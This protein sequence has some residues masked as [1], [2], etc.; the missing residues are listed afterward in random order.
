MLLLAPAH[1]AHAASMGPCRNAG[2]SRPAPSPSCDRSAFAQLPTES[3]Q[4]QTQ[5]QLPVHPGCDR[6]CL[7]EWHY[8]PPTRG[9][10]RNQRG[11]LSP[12]PFADHVPQSPDPAVY[13]WKRALGAM[14]PTTAPVW[15]P[16]P[17]HLHSSHRW[18][19]ATS[20]SQFYKFPELS[21]ICLGCP[22]K[23]W[24]L[25][26]PLCHSAAA[27]LAYHTPA[28]LQDVSSYGVFLPPSPSLW[29][30]PAVP[31]IPCTCPATCSPRPHGRRPLLLSAQLR[32]HFLCPLSHKLA[33]H[34]VLR[35]RHNI[36]HTVGAQNPSV[37]GVDE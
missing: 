10:G 15:T 37:E 11:T 35:A 25:P 34:E 32:C 19:S 23:I 2:G 30:L 27:G 26:P 7:C 31:G 21:P 13:L 6:P 24:L 3:L 8:L 20:L 4:P 16:A 1:S 17:A 5:H 29:R 36:G 28:T 33:H 18:W 14:D 22:F 9:Q 12:L